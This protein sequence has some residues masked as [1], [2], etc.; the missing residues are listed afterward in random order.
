M[1]ER[2]I[3]SVA[4]Y[5]AQAKRYEQAGD[6]QA[7]MRSYLIATH[8]QM[9]QLAP[10]D[11]AACF[12]LGLAFGQAG[13]DSRAQAAFKAALVLEPMHGDAWS[14]L[15]VLSNS[16]GPLRH[17]LSLVPNRADRH[18]NLA[19]VLLNAGQFA[20]GF[21]EWEWRALSPPRSFAQP[22]W[23]GSPYPGKTLLIHAE[24]GFGD[25]IQFCRYLPLAA[26]LGGRLIVEMRPPLAGLI[27]RLEGVAELVPWGAPLP[28][29]DLQLPL[30]SLANLFHGRPT[31]SPYLAADPARVKAWRGRVETAGKRKVGLIWA[32]NPDGHDKR[33]AAPFPLISSLVQGFP[34]IAFFS[35]QREGNEGCE[36]LTAL[37]PMIGDFDDAAAA[38]ASL[39]L[40]I[41]VDTA[42]AHL[43]GALGH[44]IWVLLR[45]GHDW[46]WRGDWYPRARLYRQE[47]EGDWTGVLTRVAEDL[48]HA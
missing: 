2:R 25:C 34:G 5:A 12:Q 18:T 23:D 28:P 30:P 43:A 48:G 6:V 14:N 26:K 3:P 42:A 27:G 46:R 39:D 41:S 47:T 16:A 15:G 31:P 17:A 19:H 10:N 29:F 35:L 13:E 22:R 32:G 21:R 33:R 36:D 11:A 8:L 4:D 9:L 24:Q 40:L 44:E 1:D 7:A 38:L 37:G 20:E 45:A